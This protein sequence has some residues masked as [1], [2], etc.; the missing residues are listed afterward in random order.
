[1]VFVACS[2]QEESMP[3]PLPPPPACA[4]VPPDAEP[5][6]GALFLCEGKRSVRVDVEV[7]TGGINTCLAPKPVQDF[8]PPGPQGPLL[9]D[10]DLN[11]SQ[12]F[13]TVE[14]LPPT[15][16]CCNPESEAFTVVGLVDTAQAD[17]A[18]RACLEAHDRF[19]IFAFVTELQFDAADDG[20]EKNGLERAFKSM[21]FYVQ[22]LEDPGSFANCT[23][24]LA[25][26]G[27]N[28]NFPDAPIDGF[29]ALKSLRLS[30]FECDMDPLP[31]EGEP[32][33]P[34]RQGSAA[35]SRRT[36]SPIPRLAGVVRPRQRARRIRTGSKE[37]QESQ[38][39]GAA[40]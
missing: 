2:D 39:S 13:T 22:V 31:D 30:D 38:S 5:F 6:T 9:T 25:G 19:E 34:P 11:V 18:A 37:T 7:C 1:M 4:A 35:F 17:C 3:P 21:N 23:N 8:N 32:V 20:I 27:H 33:D 29:G 26:D 16:A 10:D 15:G 40:S 12:G 36:R 24:G 14:P 28:Y